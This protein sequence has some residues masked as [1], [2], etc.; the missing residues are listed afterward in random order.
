MRDLND[1]IPAGS[2]WTLTEARAINSSGQIAGTG[3]IGG[4]RHAFLLT[5]TSSVASCPL[6]GLVPDGNFEH[7]DPWPAW[8]TQTSTFFGTPL[9][10]VPS[11]GTGGGTAGPYGG[12]NWAWFG[13]VGAAPE[14]ATLG[15]RMTLPRSGDLKLP[16][17]MRM[18]AVTPP[19][20]DV[21]AVSVDGV[22]VQSFPEPASPQA[23]YS[24]REVDLTRFGDGQVHEVAFTYSHPNP[25]VA[26]F[27]L[28]DVALADCLPATKFGMQITYLPFTS[29]PRAP[30]T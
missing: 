29:R 6:T 19:F 21:L 30:I 16:F 13:G 11:C 7:G 9:C 15:Q 8:T 22:T 17:Q 18:G 23:A 28:D 4:E 3:L 24:L 25:G 2:G 26:N 1:L 20:T 5:P 27:T 14:L 12:G 10:N